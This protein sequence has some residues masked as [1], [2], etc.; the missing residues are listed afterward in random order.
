MFALSRALHWTIQ[1]LI[2][3][4]KNANFGVVQAAAPKNIDT[5]FAMLHCE[6]LHMATE[7]PKYGMALTKSRVAFSDIFLNHLD[8]L[9]FLFQTLPATWA[10]RATARGSGWRRARCGG[11][12]ARRCPATRCRSSSGSRETR[13]SRRPKLKKLKAA[14]L[15]V[16]KY[17]LKLIGLT[18]EKLIAA[19][20]KIKQ[21]GS[22]SLR[23]SS[24]QSGKLSVFGDF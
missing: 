23:V 7:D 17:Q 24:S 9:H 15:S 4:C 19:E 22:P 6:L 8:R 13:E 3:L 2:S 14:L 1:T 16:Q 11:S 5:Q 21:Q 12:S 18:M 20:L 10:S